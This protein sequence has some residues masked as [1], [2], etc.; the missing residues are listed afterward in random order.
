MR[1]SKTLHTGNR[2]LHTRDGQR[3]FLRGVNLPLF[4]DWNFPGSDALAEIEKTNA[5]AV[6]IQWYVNYGNPD[7][8]SV[9]LDDLDGILGRCGAAEMIPILM[10]A[11]LT[12]TSDA[13]LVNSKLM[14]WWTSGEVVAVLQKHAKYLIVNLGNEVGFYRWADDSA[15]ALA[16]YTAAYSQAILDFRKTGLAIP[17]MIDAPDCGS[18]I[19]AFLLMG[20]QLVDAD[21][22]RNVLLST[23]AYWAAYDGIPF[24]KQCVS[25]GLP[26]VFGEISNKQD[27][28]V[29]GKTAYCFYDLDG[30]HVNPGV[31]NGFTYQALLTALQKDS[32]GWLAW[33]WGPDNCADRCLSTDGSFASLTE[34]GMDIVNNPIYGLVATAHRS[35]LL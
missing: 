25:A 27:E 21:P 17:I 2:Y 12:C 5:N 24:I 33:S 20:Q 15:A 9:T 28:Q 6:R 7:R 19:E 32:L 3:I 13:N 35:K 23:H 16:S 14:P 26:I 1:M 11:D 4:D 8:P 10:L 31:G 29:D 34:Y 18:S 22:K 30:S